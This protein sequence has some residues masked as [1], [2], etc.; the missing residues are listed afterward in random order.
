VIR[1]LMGVIVGA[2][3]GA[4][5]LYVY[6]K[7]PLPAAAPEEKPIAGAATSAPKQPRGKKGARPEAPREGGV[8]TIRPEDLKRVSEGESL[9]PS[10]ARVD[11]SEVDDSHDLTQGEIDGAVATQADGIIRCITDARG[12][13]EVS[14]EI[15]AGML[16]D[17]KGSVARTRVEA[18]AYLMK[19]GLGTC[20]RP[21]LAQVRF[22]APGRETVVTVPFRV[23]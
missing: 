18:P 6:L 20:V 8:I 9:K 5:A 17:A 19:R 4:G 13:A 16:V 15:T 23:D 11:M 2:V 7:R 22:P 12:E 14:G 1:F 3:L 21:L 10:A